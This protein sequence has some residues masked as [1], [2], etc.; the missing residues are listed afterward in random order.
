MSDLQMSEKESSKTMGKDKKM[1]V[2]LILGIG[3]CILVIVS[4]IT[5]VRRFKDVAEEKVETEQGQEIISEDDSRLVDVGSVKYDFESA[6]YNFERLAVLDLSLRNYAP[7]QKQQG[8]EWDSTLFYTLEDV[9][10]DSAADNQIANYQIKNYEFLNTQTQGVIRCVTYGVPDSGQIEKIVTI[11]SQGGAYLVSD[12]YYDNGK[13]NFVFTRTVDVYTP[14]YATIDK[15]GNRYYFNNDV[16]VRYRRIDVPKQIEQQT[17]NPSA[18]WYPNYSYFELPDEER[19]IYDDVE[20][21]VLNEAY[22][23]WN[24]VQNE[25]SF[26]DIKGYVYADGN[27]P[28][29]GAS[30]AIIASADNTVLYTTDTGEDGYYHMYALLDGTACYLQIYAEGYL[31]AYIYNVYLDESLSENNFSRLQLAKEGAEEVEVQFCLYDATALTC[32]VEDVRLSDGQVIIRSGW[33]VKGGES[34]AEGVLESQ[35]CSI[36]LKPGVYTAEF[37]M[38]GYTTTYE[39]FSVTGERCVVKGYTVSAIT[40]DSHK[41][42]LCW[43]SD[44]DLDLVLYTP[45]KSAYGDMNY[46]SIRQPQDN[47]QNFLFADGTDS[48][49]EVMQ[50]GNQL[51][52]TYKLYVNDYTSFSNGNYDTSA[53]ADSKA[54]VYIYSKDGLNAVYYIDFSQTGIIWNVCEIGNDGYHPGFI[55]FSNINGYMA[56]DKSPLTEGEVLEMYK[57]FLRGNITAEYEGKQITYDELVDIFREEMF[58]EDCLRS[59][60]ALTDSDW[61][62]IPE[63]QI[64]LWNFVGQMLYSVTFINHKLT[65][66]ECLSLG[67]MDYLSLYANGIYGIAHGLSTNETYWVG[68]VDGN[69][70][71]YFCYSP[72]D[73]L[74]EE[75]KEG[76]ADWA[77]EEYERYLVEGYKYIYIVYGNDE[78]AYK[79]SATYDEFITDYCGEEIPFYE[80]NET[81]IQEN[82]KWD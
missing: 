30:V 64:D 16:L 32:G 24:A 40:D 69:K 67:Y 47:Y 34:V 28:L 66:C 3:V 8:M 82:M 12:Y 70:Y 72:I 10:A 71:A 79:F 7:G 1:S 61:D 53:L 80:V 76:Y 18:T 57:E 60:F 49:C 50:I 11:E 55:V 45:E 5:S 52:G 43:D 42:V 33:N 25:N 75:H 4:A 63:L 21:Q 65:I 59:E 56:I 51:A 39:N 35:N 13:V 36:Q 46:I 78:V 48:H 73:P 29:S 77:Q 17:L 27:T 74:T 38:N 62:N 15:V 14:T 44:L 41:A 31:P 58:S 26:F 20:L 19:E 23:V 37:C 6:K 68:D 9:Y 2:P 22:N 54:R 81:S